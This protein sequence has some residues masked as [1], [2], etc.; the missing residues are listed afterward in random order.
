MNISTAHNGII[1]SFTLAILDSWDGEIFYVNADG[2]LVYY[3][4][5]VD[6]EA[7]SNTCLNSW[8]D[9]YV[10]VQ[11]GFNHSA[12][13]LALNFSSMLDQDTDDKAWG[14]CNLTIVVSESYVDKDGNVLDIEASGEISS[15]VFGC[16]SAAYEDTWRYAPVY[17]S[18]YCNDIYFVGP[19]GAGGSLSAVLSVPDDHTSLIISF[20]LA[21]LDSWDNEA[22]QVIADG[23]MVYNISHTGKDGTSNTCQNGWNDEY[24]EVK[25]EFSHNGKYVSV[26]FI[27]TLDQPSN[28]E[29]WGICNLK[30]TATT[31]N[32][33]TAEEY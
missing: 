19:F 3:L 16:D 32:I 26:L 17:N 11:F 7:T 15:L 13:T 1:V 21:L 23:R 2:S 27:S 14:L 10:Q 18:F 4:F 33:N 28:D 20:Q 29:A 12:T 25:F 22:F 9:N 8:A 6:N 24:F 5:A 30:I 31:G